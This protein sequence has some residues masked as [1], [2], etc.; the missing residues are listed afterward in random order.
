MDTVSYRKVN[1][2]KRKIDKCNSL[3]DLIESGGD[4]QSINDILMAIKSSQSAIEKSL[5]PSQQNT[6]NILS[7]EESLNRGYT[8]T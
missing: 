5:Q 8:E 1:E 2:L 3:Q 4:L 7:I 6:N